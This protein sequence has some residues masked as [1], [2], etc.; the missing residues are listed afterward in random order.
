MSKNEYEFI[1]SMERKNNCNRDEARRLH[2][3]YCKY[4]DSVRGK[5]LSPDCNSCVPEI[6]SS[7]IQ[8]INKEGFKV[9]E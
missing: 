1:R 9:E 8:Y 5:V 2:E 6:F 7:C 4:V 3:I